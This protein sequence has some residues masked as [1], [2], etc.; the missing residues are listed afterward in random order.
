MPRGPDKESGKG[1]VSRRTTPKVTEDI[2]E[3]DEEE[4]GDVADEAQCIATTSD[5]ADDKER[6][7]VVW[8]QSYILGTP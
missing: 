1:F 5:D 2:K 3:E 7:I 8:Y 6:V 4:G